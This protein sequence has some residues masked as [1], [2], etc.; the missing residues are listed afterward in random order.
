M[1]VTIFQLCDKTAQ[2]FSD[3]L[4]KHGSES[5]QSTSH[6]GLV[7]D[8]EFTSTKFRRAHISVVDA[9]NTH[10]I[11]FFHSLIFPNLND[12]SPIF[13]F[14]V[15]AG[16]NKVSGAFHDFSPVSSDE[17]YMSTW[18][19][20]ETSTLSWN[21]R[22]ELPGWAQNI[23]SKNIIAI[24]AADINETWDFVNLGLRNLEF[25]L[26]WLGGNGDSCADYSTGQNYYCENQR[27]NPYTA[28]VLVNLGFTEDQAQE[29]V[30]K[31]LFPTV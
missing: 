21:K 25:Y 27:L 2:L 17:S 1:T 15:I 12:P 11:W 20:H 14:D 19:K 29:Y 16:K 3:K 9:R 31:T 26:Y 30:F 4:V 10:G 22:R 13:G 5:I 6:N 28:K 24:G 8:I 7:T 23:F 18:F